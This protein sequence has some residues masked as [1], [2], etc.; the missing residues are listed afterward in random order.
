MG[1]RLFKKILSALVDTLPK[2][3][4]DHSV[5]DHAC[6]VD[7]QSSNGKNHTGDSEWESVYG[8][9]HEKE[10]KRFLG[11]IFHESRTT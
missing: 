6:P 5:T 11:P 8:A 1:A 4:P 9:G 7:A 10:T 2:S 3:G